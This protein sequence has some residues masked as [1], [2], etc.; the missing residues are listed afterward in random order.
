MRCNFCDDVLAT[1]ADARML[2]CAH[3]A[4]EPCLLGLH[5][6]G[7]VCLHCAAAFNVADVRAP[8][9]CT[10]DAAAAVSTAFWDAEVQRVA[11]HV[12]AAHAH[13]AAADDYAI[14]VRQ[15]ALA[16]IDAHMAALKANRTRIEHDVDALVAARTKVMDDTCESSAV[17][18][19]QCH[20]LR[21]MRAPP[22]HTGTFALPALPPFRFEVVANAGAM[23]GSIQWALYADAPDPHASTLECMDVN[24]DGFEARR[25]VIVVPR[26][27]SGVLLPADCLV[28]VVCVSP[29]PGV[30]V[31]ARL[32]QKQWRLCV[33]RDMGG[34]IVVNVLT[35]GGERFSLCTQLR[36]LHEVLSRTFVPEI[37]EFTTCLYPTVSRCARY[38][39]FANWD[40]AQ[41]SVHMYILDAQTGKV[42]ASK[43]E[44]SDAVYGLHFVSD[45]TGT[46]V[47]LEYGYVLDDG[48]A[49]VYPKIWYAFCPP[50]TPLDKDS[51]DAI[52]QQRLTTWRGDG[53]V[54]LHYELGRELGRNQAYWASSPKFAWVAECDLAVLC[55]GFVY[56]LFNGVVT[57]DGVPKPQFGTPVAIATSTQQL[58]VTYAATADTPAHIAVFDVV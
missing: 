48:A 31:A 47:A 20:A 23:P 11:A 6:A 43:T 21:D 29:R 5:A 42:R 34:D 22:A 37:A 1:S 53:H 24:V 15:R 40:A 18:L 58:F 13:R 57:R 2:P 49:S 3:V 54:E 12:Q 38:Y 19:A 52:P 8:A 50:D 45:L 35:R 7:A 10:D 26:D 36:A 16:D 17:T 32:V 39:A 30:D 4:C 44:H 56:M 27:G 28:D 9:T 46:V 14:S 33:P 41:A 51:D 25:I 55:R